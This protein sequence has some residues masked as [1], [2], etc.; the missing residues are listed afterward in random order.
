MSLKNVKTQKIPDKSLEKVEAIQE[1]SHR[2]E[3]RDVVQSS[4]RLERQKIQEV[5]L[6]DVYI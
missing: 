5:S 6:E 4:E 3:G 2:K 1:V